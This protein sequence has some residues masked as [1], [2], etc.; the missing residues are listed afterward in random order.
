MEKSESTKNVFSA[1]VQAQSEFRTLPKDKSGYGYKYTDLD[2]VINT[3]RPI[4]AKHGLAFTQI[5]DGDTLET[6][7]VH[8][9]SGEYFGGSAKLPEIALS[10]K[11]NEAQNLGAAMTYMRRYGLCSILGISSDEDVDSAIP[12]KTQEQKAQNQERKESVEGP[13]KGKPEVEKKRLAGG[14]TTEE[15]KKKLL[16]LLDYTYADGSK[17]FGKDAIK[18]ASKMREKQTAKEVIDCFKEELNNRLLAKG[19]SFFPDDIPF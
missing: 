18:A 2:T 19:E 15:E 6:F 17:V 10:S 3:V 16:Y 7:I 12:S 9:E 8:K 4:L 1:F 5:E 13:Q 14:E 11:T